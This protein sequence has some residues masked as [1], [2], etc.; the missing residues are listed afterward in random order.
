MFWYPKGKDFDERDADGVAL[1]D[2]LKSYDPN[3]Y[4]RPSVTVDMLVFKKEAEGLK[5]LLIRRGR[6][7][8]YGKFALPGGFL[9]MDETLGDA[10]ARELFEETGLRGVELTQLGA[11]GDIGR[12]PR[13]RIIS[14]AYT[15]V[16]EGDANPKAGDDAADAGF[17]GITLNRKVINSEKV[18]RLAFSNGMNIARSK[19]KESAN[20]RTIIDSDVASDH[21]IMILD[22]LERLGFIENM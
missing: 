21:S 20:K 22:A 10:A 5:I 11:Y 13:T 4:D 7:P 3:R 9:E 19:L 14:V 6:H 8:S 2:F 18:Y 1:R 15:A 17:Y 12:D 16:L